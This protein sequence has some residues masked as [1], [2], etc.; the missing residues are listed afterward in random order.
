MVR[1]SWHLFPVG[2][3]FGLGFDTAT[4]VALFGMS[5]TQA[6]G[7]ASFGTLLVFPALFTAG[8]VA[9][10]HRRRRRM[11]RPG[12]AF[13]KPIRKIYYNLTITAVSV[14]V[15]L[16]IGGVETLGMIGEGFDLHGGFWDGVAA[17]NANFGLLGYSIIGLFLGSWPVS[18][19]FD[20][21]KGFDRLEAEA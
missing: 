21:L 3:L 16:A 6:A 12:W 2:L 17:L 1:R 10:R 9:G 5:A 11:P 19:R 20:R 8:H 4:E 15:A 7:G 13:M 18:A 14:L